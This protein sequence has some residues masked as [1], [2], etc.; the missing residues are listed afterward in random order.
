LAFDASGTFQL[1]RSLNLTKKIEQDFSIDF[2]EEEE[3]LQ[4]EDAMNVIW[5]SVVRR[6]YP[7][8]QVSPLHFN[9]RELS[10]KLKSARRNDAFYRYAYM[11]SKYS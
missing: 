7:N 10:K 9:W 1:T 4:V 3:R 11:A 6:A 8:A 2:S 5:H